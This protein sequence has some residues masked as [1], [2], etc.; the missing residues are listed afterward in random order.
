[1]KTI[2]DIYLEWMGTRD[3]LVEEID[4]AKDHGKPYTVGILQNVVKSISMFI[5][6]LRPFLAK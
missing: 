5:E 2:D 6:D 1:M 4:K 3:I